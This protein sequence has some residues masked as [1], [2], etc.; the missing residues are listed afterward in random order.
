VELKTVDNTCNPYL[1]FGAI[2]AAGLDGIERQLDPGPDL[3][4]DPGLLDDATRAE[5]NMARLP[6]SLDQALD[7]LEADQVLLDALGPTLAGAYVTVRRSEAR[8]Y[9]EMDEAT[10]FEM[11]RLTY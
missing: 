5:R 1:A 2:M 4:I 3:D 11:H 7:N 9:A 10:A 8:S 6:T